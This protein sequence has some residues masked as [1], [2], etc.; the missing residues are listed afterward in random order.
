M[1]LQKFTKTET[2]L[3]KKKLLPA[4]VLP[5]TQEERRAMEI[6][7]NER[8]SKM[9]GQER[10]DFL[11]KVEEIVPA[12]SEL[13]NQRWEIN[14]SEVSRV[15][16]NFIREYNR[17]PTKNEIAKD[18]GLSRQTVHKHLL[19]FSD[20]EFYNEANQKLKILNHKLMAKV[21]QA[22][23][24]GSVKAARLYFEMT[25]ELGRKTTKNYYI[26][27][28]NLRVDEALIKSLPAETLLQIEQ[29]ISQSKSVK[30][31]H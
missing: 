24:D 2:L 16:S 25:G 22:A 8:L 9:Q 12:N 27:I 23:F 28:N 15:I 30:K 11:D 14:H 3:S 26:Q 17:I 5:L 7:I 1:T 20:S 21:Y 19:E 10:E 29:L 6:E 4:D 13:K 31:L 18:T